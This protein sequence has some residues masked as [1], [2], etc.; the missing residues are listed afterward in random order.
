MNCLTGFKE[1][2]FQIGEMI[3]LAVMMG[4]GAG[5]V[6]R[7]SFTNIGQIPVDKREHILRRFF[8]EE[9]PFTTAGNINRR[10]VC[11]ESTPPTII[12]RNAGVVRTSTSR[13]EPRVTFYFYICLQCKL[14]RPL[15][16]FRRS[17]NA[18]L[19]DNFE[20]VY[21]EDDL[22][23]FLDC[24]RAF[25]LQLHRITDLVAFHGEMDDGSTAEECSTP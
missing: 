3:G 10:S 20:C 8:V 11:K 5:L 15:I 13:G 1:R 21:G 16:I 4:R 18:P 7:G 6:S 19:L 12:M 25:A 23:P 24:N 9:P 2:T 17:N 22:C 14:S